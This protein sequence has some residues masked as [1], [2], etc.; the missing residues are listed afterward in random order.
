[1]NRQQGFSLIS[2]MIGMVLGVFLVAAVIRIYSDTKTSFMVRDV[3]ANVAENQR[4]ALDD[5]RRILVMAGRNIRAV[6]DSSSALRPFPPLADNET[7]ALATGAALQ[8]DGGNSGSDVI[9]VRYRRGPSC[10]AYQDVA[11]TTQPSM[12]RFL[13]VDNDLV[14]E[15]TSYEGSTTT[16]RSV[17]VSNIERLKVLYGVDDDGDRYANR[18]LTGSQVAALG[19]DYASTWGQVVSVR[20]GVLAASDMTLPASARENST[21]SYSVLGM[22]Y[23][24]PDTERLR[25]VA[26]TTFTFRNLNPTVQRQ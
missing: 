23:T 17:L 18:Y 3:V 21:Q 4:F 19:A 11:L 5:M 6:E 8:W 20:L 2:L 12:V 10:G 7:A 16:T 9:A 24:A 1:M 15:L 25:R 22:S 13:V 26:S 14:C